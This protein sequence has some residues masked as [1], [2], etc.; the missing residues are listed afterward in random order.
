MANPQP[1]MIR[2]VK[3]GMGTGGQFSR[4]MLLRPTSPAMRLSESIKLPKGVGSVIA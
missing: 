4:G 2:N 1:T 3:N